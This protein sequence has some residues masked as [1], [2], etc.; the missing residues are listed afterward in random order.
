[1]T[2][3]QIRAFNDQQRAPNAADV[4]AELEVMIPDAIGKAQSINEMRAAAAEFAR[5]A[6]DGKRLGEA[7]RPQMGFVHTTAA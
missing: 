5:R 2:N 1:L 7:P 6:G 3:A 4:R